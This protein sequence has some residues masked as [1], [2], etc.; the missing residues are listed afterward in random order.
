MIWFLAIGTALAR[1]RVY[2][3]AVELG[4]ETA[5]VRAVLADMNRS[6]KSASSTIDEVTAAE[7]RSKLGSLQGSANLGASGNSDP[8]KIPGVHQHLNDWPP[9]NAE[10]QLLDPVEFLQPDRRLFIDTNVFMET[11]PRREGG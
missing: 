7:V 1:M 11:D 9:K 10:I 3:L 8:R 4:V 6:V 2:D 5:T